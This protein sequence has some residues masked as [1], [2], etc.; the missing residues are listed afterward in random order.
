MTTEISLSKKI[1]NPS[2]S[3]SS[4]MS[5]IPKSKR[6]R[7]F[8]SETP[9]PGSYDINR[10]SAPS[11]TFPRT[12]RDPFVRPSETPGPGCYNTPTLNKGP[13]FTV[14]TSQKR[15]ISPISPGPAYYETRILSRP[16]SVVFSRTQRKLNTYETDVPGPG[17]YSSRPSSSHSIGTFPKA[18]KV[19]K[20]ENFEA[21]PGSYNLISKRVFKF[22]F[23][24]ER[25]KSPF[26]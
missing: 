6:F 15:T 4:K 20:I 12:K 3:S 24:K 17:H 10:A 26:G 25:R 19:S 18:S 9:G 21:G 13:Q 7:N 1:S 8:V 23:T 16:K 5:T 14:Q 2:F 22:A 11:I